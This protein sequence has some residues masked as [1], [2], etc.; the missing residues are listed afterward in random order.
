MAF[1]VYVTGYETGTTLEDLIIYF[2]S[3][4][5]GGG[6]I[7]DEECMFDQEEAVIAFDEDEG[8]KK[9]LSENVNS[10]SVVQVRI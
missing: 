6:D 5:S 2:Q 1:K 9:Q 8:K 3:K 7:D 10:I 4:E